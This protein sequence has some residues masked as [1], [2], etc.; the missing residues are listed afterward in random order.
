MCVIIAITRKFMF[1]YA[2]NSEDAK[3]HH[4]YVYAYT[5]HNAHWTVSVLQ[6]MRKKCISV[7]ECVWKLKENLELIRVWENKNN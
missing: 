3:N 7:T 2:Y 4:S 1:M 5:L 6:A